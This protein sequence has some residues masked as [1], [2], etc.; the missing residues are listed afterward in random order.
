MDTARNIPSPTGR[1]VTL[2]FYWG[3]LVIGF[4]L[5]WVTTV[6]VDIGHRHRPV[7]EAVA[8]FFSGFWLRLFAPG[9]GLLWLA[10]LGAAPFA[11]FAVF[12]LL[13]LGTAWRHGLDVARRRI[14]GVAF[15]FAAM[16]AISIWGHVS[17]MTAR[18]STAGIG[19]LFLPI[20]TLFALP[21]GYGLG[22]LVARIQARSA[23]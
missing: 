6:A 3:S 13:H 8:S 2:V 10:L 7:A 17:I 22:R 12:T 4:L 15:A 11:V 19:F 5:P 9:E 21:V 18:G 23:N 1:A 16:L 14:V 20:Y